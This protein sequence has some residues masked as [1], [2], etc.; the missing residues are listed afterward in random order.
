MSSVVL[1]LQNEI[2]RPDC[3][4]VSILRKAH[5][6]AAKL[7]LKEF[8]QWIINE[9]NGYGGNIE[10]IPNYRITRGVLKAFNPYR[11]WIPTM[12]QDPEFEKAVC[13]R[14]IPNSLS[15]IIALCATSE[16]GLICELSG[17][18]MEIL[19]KVFDVPLPMKYSLHLST[20]S[21]ADIVE[22]VKNT[23]LEW[24]IKLEAEGIIGEDL[25]FTVQE[26]ESAKKM[27]QTVN[28]YYG[29]TNI[30][31]GNNNTVGFSY[32]DAKDAVREIKSAIETDSLSQEDRDT[33]LE[34]LQDIDRKILEQKKPSVIKSLLSG[35]K[36]F[37]I[38]GGASLAAG[39]IQAK[40]QG[41]F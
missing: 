26:R 35:L 31:T 2:I 4:V 38:N 11:G 6:I 20:T 16:N 18:Q 41:L 8:D 1:E 17:E 40:L 14:P 15:E 7:Q 33:A 19:N 27:P 37:L 13:E 10:A 39:I 36:D 32:G 12:I 23:I 9:L 28:N 30:V 22:K 21:I 25:V 5:L 34:L 3:D 29:P 24:T